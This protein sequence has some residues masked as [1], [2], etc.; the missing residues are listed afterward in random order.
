MPVIAT[1][2][3]ERITPTGDINENGVV[4]IGDVFLAIRFMQAITTPTLQQRAR[5]DIMPVDS[6]GT[7]VPDGQVDPADVL[8]LYQL[9]MG[10]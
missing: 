1:L 5:A 2:H 10:I 4:D 3:F 8:K 6:Q 9:A 7:P